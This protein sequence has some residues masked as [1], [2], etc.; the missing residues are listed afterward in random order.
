MVL[1]APYAADTADLLAAVA[2]RLRCA[3]VRRTRRERVPGGPHGRGG[4]REFS[5][6]LFGHASD[7]E[8]SE[9]LFTSLLLQ[10]AHGLAR[11]AVPEREHKAAFR[12]SWLAG[13][14]LAVGRRLDEAERRAEAEAEARYARAGTS[15]GLVLAD[16]TAVVTAATD[17]AYPHLGPVRR[18]SLSGSGTQQGWAAGQ[19]ANLGGTALRGRRAL[20]GGP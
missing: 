12:R 14:R 5:V 15:T 16:R 6:H 2:T 17:N 4:D 7:L 19:R 10:S 18:R 9:L 3:T 8:R 1:D 11:T 20:A 13:F